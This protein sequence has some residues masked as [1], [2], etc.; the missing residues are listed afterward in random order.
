M[1]A[2]LCHSKKLPRETPAMLKP[3][4]LIP[5]VGERSWLRIYFE[6]NTKKMGEETFF[7]QT[8]SEKIAQ[9]IL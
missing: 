2:H 5:T 9:N 8:F 3:M 7:L 6:K 4:V 1:V